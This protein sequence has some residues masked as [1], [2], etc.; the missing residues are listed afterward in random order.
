MHHGTEIFMVGA[1]LVPESYTCTVGKVPGTPCNQDKE[2]PCW[3]PRPAEKT[4]CKMSLEANC[5]T[6]LNQ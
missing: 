1:F 2:I 3:V 4:V 6:V 5:N